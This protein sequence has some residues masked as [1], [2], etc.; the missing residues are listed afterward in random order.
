M[1]LA[2]IW[3]SRIEPV[4]FAPFA[5]PKTGKLRFLRSRM[6]THIFRFRQAPCARREA[7]NA[8][9][10]DGIVELPY[11]LFIAGYNRPPTPILHDLGSERGVLFCGFHKI[12]P[13][14]LLLCSLL[15]DFLQLVSFPCG[16]FGV[17]I[18]IRRMLKALVGHLNNRLHC[19]TIRILLSNSEFQTGISEA[20]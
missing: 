19:K 18:W 17:S 15:F 16:V 7:V 2:A 8:R 10:S 13:L 5:W 14:F 11:R 20:R 1:R 12:T 9:G 3:C 6:K 4:G